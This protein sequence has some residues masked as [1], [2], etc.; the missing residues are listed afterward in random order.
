MR[1][2]IP[3]LLFALALTIF[4]PAQDLAP[5]PVPVS[6]F[7]VPPGFVVE[8]IAAPP[9]VRYPLFAALDERGRMFVAEGTGTN[10]PGTELAKKK[11]GRIVLLED[12]D[13]DG[14]YDTSKVFVDKLIFP[15]GVLW[16]DGAL[17]CASHP[18]FWKFQDTKGVG[19]ADKL[20]ELATGFKFNGNGCDIHGPFLGPDG[21][22]YWTDGR[23]GY[24][25]KS[26]DGKLFEGL[27]ARIW[28]SRT[29]GTDLEQICGGGFD[30][31]VEIAF[32]PEGEPIGTMDQGAGDCLLHYVDGA[33]FPIEH[34][35][36][37]EF[38]RTGPLLTPIKQYS[39]ALPPALCGFTRYRS[40]HLGKAFQ[41]TFF[42]TH[43][44]LHRLVQNRLIRDGSTF[45]SEDRNFLTSEL[46]DVR[47][48][49]V[50]EDA[51]GSLLF[52]DMGA[53]FTYGYVKPTLPKPEVLGGIYRIRR[54]DGKRVADPWGKSLKLATL[55]TAELAKLLDD[56][57]PM[58]RDQAILHLAKRFGA[59]PTLSGMLDPARG[60]SVQGRR[61]AVWAL[62]RMDDA[63]ASVPLRGALADKD[64]SVRMAAV[65]ASGLHRD[66]STL[67]T[68]N[69]MVVDE[70]PPLRLKA[71]EALGRI[72]KADAVPA[73]LESLR[74][75]GDSFLE[76]ALIY[77]LI[78]VND[79]KGTAVALAD[80]NPRLRRAALVALDQM[81]DGNL[82]QAQVVPLLDTDD[83]A[84]QQTALEVISRRPGWSG[85]VQGLLRKW[86]ALP[87]LSTE[88]EKSLTGALLGFS[89]EKDIQ[90]LMAES[91]STRDTPAATRVLLLGVL[92]RCRL[93]TLP[94]PWLKALAQAL[95]DADS[96]VRREAVTAIKTRNLRQFD[97]PLLA[98]SRHTKLPAEL[99]IAA[100]ET[101]AER[102]SETDAES[103]A[104]L[105]AH[106][107]EKTDPLLRLS[108][109]RALGANSLSRQQLVDLA[110][111]LPETSTLVLRQLLPAFARSKDVA[112]GKALV[113]A[114]DKTP[115][116]E[117]LTVDELDKTL[118]PHAP[119]VHEQA[120]AFRDRLAA[121]QQ[122]QTAYI[123]SL[124]DELDKLQGN[125]DAGKQVFFSQKVG[126][127]VCHKVGTQGGVIG[128]DLSKIGG[129]RSPAELLE[130]IVFPTLT[131]T[132]EFRTYQVQTKSGRS[133]DGLIFRETADAIFLRTAQLAEVRVPRKDVED[134]VPSST[135]LMPDGLDRTMLRQELRDVLEFL[136]GLK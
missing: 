54:V 59:I 18:S 121:R 42:S 102:R 107:S 45:R 41:D 106:L 72:G 10:L 94:P 32:T 80:A 52:V 108:A 53:W 86:L 4:A 104:L 48:T 117:A 66:A 17:Y 101:V 16:H 97:E 35:C 122:K 96:A 55:P 70:V 2:T 37:K 12:T 132:P 77:A 126:C 111:R 88:L 51:D 120:R 3:A 123:V 116:A 27:A 125:G 68:L 24:K 30:N 19:K 56:P 64:F 26:R 71:A 82:A 63:R 34:P 1:C 11:L 23:H 118:K 95:A 20:E 25:F 85:A 39:A 31:P 98:L 119:E 90:A 57:R 62:C 115:T 130:A 7:K 49:D 105:T 43:Y 67:P 73:L 128:P 5:K 50:L 129:F 38:V 113:A 136:R 110:R 22:L 87:K 76:H 75:G 44:M 81:K 13:G 9:L 127:H 36:I 47:I 33:V 6:A 28:R 83:A 74:K 69:R 99:R 134:L 100:M 29:D 92:A 109:A 15:Q 61:N 114:L 93:D 14:I 46:Q 124:R 8:R 112:A 89:G 91:L 135:S 84:L 133:F 78:R 65:H 60:R 131:I 40:D 21:R 58:V 79:P 103:F